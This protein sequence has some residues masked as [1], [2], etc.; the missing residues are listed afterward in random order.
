MESKQHHT[1][2]LQEKKA[3]GRREKSLGHTVAQLVALFESWSGVFL[4]VL[5]LVLCR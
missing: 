4:H 1:A 3:L 5:A 2:L